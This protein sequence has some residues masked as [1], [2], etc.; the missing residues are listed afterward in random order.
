MGYNLVPFKERARGRAGGSVG[1]KI[2]GSEE[3]SRVGALRRVP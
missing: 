1:L 3:P 2:T